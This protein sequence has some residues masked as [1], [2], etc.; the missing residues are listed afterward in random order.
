VLGV[1]T[2]IKFKWTNQHHQRGFTRNSPG[3]IRGNERARKTL[4]NQSTY[5]CKSTTLHPSW[6]IF[7]PLPRAS[8]AT[9]RSKVDHDGF[10]F[11]YADV[12]G[13]VKSWSGVENWC[14]V[15]VVGRRR[16]RPPFAV[17]FRNAPPTPPT[18][19]YDTKPPMFLSR[20]QRSLHHRRN[21][22][23]WNCR[24]LRSC[25]FDMARPSTIFPSY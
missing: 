5:V 6:L 14:A 21:A 10:M 22:K 7:R 12:D 17:E 9:N 13:S 8:A 16:P 1:D 3:T 18:D 23:C 4:S 11:V 2:R 25:L 19:G 15:K 20:P 24:R